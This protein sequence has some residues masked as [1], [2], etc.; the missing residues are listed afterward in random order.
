M[1]VQVPVS[2]KPACGPSLTSHT[3]TYHPTFYKCSVSFLRV[4][5]LKSAQTLTLLSCLIDWLL[6]VQVRFLFLLCS[7]LP[8]SPT[9]PASSWGGECLLHRMMTGAQWGLHQ[10]Q[11]FQYRSQPAEETS[12][13]SLP[14]LP[15]TT[16]DHT[17]TKP[18]ESHSK[19]NICHFRSKSWKFKHLRGK[20][21]LK[22][23]HD[24]WSNTGGLDQRPLGALWAD[25]PVVL[26]LTST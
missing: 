5:T 17:I 19:H 6:G 23:Q 20:A 8:R 2:W 3:W 7:Q 1:C 9:A 21:T 10:S 22:V 15:V 14:N 25:S 11:L 24:R 12:L 13:G 26:H 16:L 18:T 4:L